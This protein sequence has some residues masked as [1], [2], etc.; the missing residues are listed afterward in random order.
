MM[1]LVNSMETVEKNRCVSNQIEE[2]TELLPIQRYLLPNVLM[3]C[4]TEI[5]PTARDVL[6]GHAY[7][8][9]HGPAPGETPAR[10][11]S[12]VKCKLLGR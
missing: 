6:L 9:L 2:R 7:R 8:C 12:P 11:E 3:S 5:R 10:A 1:P 4:E